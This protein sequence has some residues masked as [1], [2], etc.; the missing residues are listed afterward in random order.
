MAVRKLGLPG[1]DAGSSSTSFASVSPTEI[2]QSNQQVAKA[3]GLT[4]D[5]VL[6]SAPVA[7]IDVKGQAN[8][9]VNDYGRMLAAVSGA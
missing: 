5:L 9:A 2:V 7:V 6:G 4:Q 3:M 1:G 8:P